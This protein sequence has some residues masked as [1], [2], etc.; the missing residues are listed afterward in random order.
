MAPG[1]VLGFTLVGNPNLEPGLVLASLIV[2]AVAM[3]T[4]MLA[5]WARKTAV[6]DVWARKALEASTNPPSASPTPLE[7]AAHAALNE[8]E[9]ASERLRDALGSLAAGSRARQADWRLIAV[10]ESATRDLMRARRSL[11]RLVGR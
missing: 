6:E 10:A 2:P 7:R 5:R 1:L 4:I 11:E 3:A 8:A 9:Q